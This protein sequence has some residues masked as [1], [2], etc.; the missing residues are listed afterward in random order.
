MTRTKL[1][2]A[3]LSGADLADVDL[4]HTD[5]TGANFRDANLTNA[6]FPINAVIPDGWTVPASGRLARATNAPGGG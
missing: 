3:N 6:W 5:I 1:V 4:P 2:R